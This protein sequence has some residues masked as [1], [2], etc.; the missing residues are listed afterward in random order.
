M[1]ITSIQI[2]LTCVSKNF[3]KL[4]YARY[5]IN[6]IAFVLRERLERGGSWEGIRSTM[7]HIVHSNKYIP[8]VAA[9]IAW[10]KKYETEM[11]AV[12]DAFV[13]AIKKSTFVHVDETGLPMEIGF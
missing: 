7:K 13:D 2:L 12:Y 6:M 8:T 3:K 1:F 11:K 4:K 5:G 10:I 9:C